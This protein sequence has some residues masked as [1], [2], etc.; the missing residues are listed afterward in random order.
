MSSEIVWNIHD[1]KRKIPLATFYDCTLGSGE[2]AKKNVFQLSLA[3]EVVEG[4][5][6]LDSMLQVIEISLLTF[7]S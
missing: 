1:H 4:Q 2:V 3:G 6:T 5:E 7:E